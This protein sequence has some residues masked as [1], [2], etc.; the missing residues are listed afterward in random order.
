MADLTPQ[1]VDWLT[2]QV[3][4]PVLATIAP[5]GRPSQSVMWAILEPD[6]TVLMNTQR[7]REKARNLSRDP[8][9]SLCYED[10]YHY[11]T[12]EGTVAFRDD[13]DLTD[14]VRLRDT[15]GDDYDF[16]SQR[17]ER[18]SLVL[19]VTRVLTHLRRL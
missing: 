7:D 2:R 18:V 15:Y 3:R 5:D 16:S 13:P 1:L 11:I 6:G 9:A 17:G 8:R 19:T 4:F 10:G 12:L 14:I